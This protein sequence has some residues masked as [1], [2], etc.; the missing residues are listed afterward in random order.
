MPTINLPVFDLD[1]SVD[2][3]LSNCD[4]HNIAEIIEALKDDGY[5]NTNYLPELEDKSNME[6]DFV[7][8][9]KDLSEKFYQLDNEAIEYIESLH[10]KWC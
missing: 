5:L 2:E 8:K 9:C 6:K 1:I 7:N 10:K 4:S 3:F